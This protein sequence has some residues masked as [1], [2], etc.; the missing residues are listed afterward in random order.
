VRKTQNRPFKNIVIV[1]KIFAC[2]IS[3]AGIIFLIYQYYNFFIRLE[4]NTAAA[5]IQ[6]I[7][8]LLGILVTLL[9]VYIQHNNEIKRNI[10]SQKKNQIEKLKVLMVM[11]FGVFI[12]CKKTAAKIRNREGLWEMEIRF[13]V[14]QRNRLS[15][16]AA[17]DI[18]YAKLYANNSSLITGLQL[19]ET[20][21]VGLNE[22]IIKQIPLSEKFYDSIELSLHTTA[23]LASVGLEATLEF[24]NN[25]SDCE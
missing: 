25:E 1:A 3:V 13:L 19:A 16:V 5:W 10:L 7:G 15:S 6:A 11:F 21:L 20:S 23:D 2:S 8:S 9:V 12:N 18:P 14:E 24:Y 4:S 22:A 17:F